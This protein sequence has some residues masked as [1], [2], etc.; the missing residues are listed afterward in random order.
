MT[1][2]WVCVSITMRE[3][4]HA[5]IFLLAGHWT[6]KSVAVYLAFRNGKSG[7]LACLACLACFACFLAIPRTGRGRW[8]L[9]GIS[10]GFP[11]TPCPAS[12]QL[13]VPTP[14]GLSKGLAQ[15]TVVT[16][17]HAMCDAALFA[18]SGVV[19]AIMIHDVLVMKMFSLCKTNTSVPHYS[20]RLCFAECPLFRGPFLP[21]S[22]NAFSRLLIHSPPLCR[23]FWQRTPDELQSGRNTSGEGHLV[24]PFNMEHASSAR[25]RTEA[26]AS[27]FTHRARNQDFLAGHLSPFSCRLAAAGIPEGVRDCGCRCKPC[28]RPYAYMDDAQFL[29][30]PGIAYRTFDRAFRRYFDCQTMRAT[31]TPDAC[32]ELPGFKG[33]GRRPVCKLPSLQGRQCSCGRGQRWSWPM[34]AGGAAAGSWPVPHHWWNSAGSCCQS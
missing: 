3:F 33:P 5:Q 30:A 26:V 25:C 18:V 13:V 22:K 10:M 9:L 6:L 20:K 16:H 31:L 19:A 11:L 24:H 15:G 29:L 32:A 21:K 27:G 12:L 1:V 28:G 2:L 17:A 7:C 23:A 8:T 14:R 34:Q 4:C